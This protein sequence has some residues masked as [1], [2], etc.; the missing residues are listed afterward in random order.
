MAQ[1]SYLVQ[2]GCAMTAVFAV[3]LSSLRINSKE[4]YIDSDDTF[5]FDSFGIQNWLS[6]GTLFSV[7]QILE[8][9]IIL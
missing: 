1:L 3:H 9:N 7:V 5:C 2:E 8:K 4:L 6:F